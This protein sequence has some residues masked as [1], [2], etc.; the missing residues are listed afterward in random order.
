MALDDGVVLALRAISA[1]KESS[2]DAGDVAVATVDAA[3]GTVDVLDE[4]TLAQHVADVADASDDA[5]DCDGS[6]AESDGA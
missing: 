2:L 1:P 6:G 3:S 4:P 5:D